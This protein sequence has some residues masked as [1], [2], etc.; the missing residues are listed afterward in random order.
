MMK[1]KSKKAVGL[2][3]AIIIVVTIGTMG[4]YIL[5]FATRNAKQ[6]ATNAIQAQLHLYTRSTVEY[7]LFLGSLHKSYSNMYACT[8]ASNHD[9]NVSKIPTNTNRPH[10][11]SITYRNE[12]PLFLELNYGTNAEYRFKV[13]VSEA[14]T[15]N[16]REMNGTIIMDIM[17]TFVGM[18]D[19]PSDDV[20]VTRKV[21]E[22]I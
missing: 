4:T 5:D 20:V 9:C 8:G 2:I 15:Q 21:L 3:Y 7:V 16:S 1:V 12:I 22:K 10:I 18:E 14:S 11:S 17:G 6:T 19:D 13:L